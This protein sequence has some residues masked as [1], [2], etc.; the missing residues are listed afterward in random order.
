MSITVAR[1]ASLDYVCRPNASTDYPC[2]SGPSPARVTGAGFAQKSSKIIKILLFRDQ[3]YNLKCIGF[4]MCQHICQLLG[5]GSRPGGVLQIL[6]LLLRG[7][8]WSWSKLANSEHVYHFINFITF[9]V[10]STD[11]AMLWFDWQKQ[12][13]T[14]HHKPQRSTKHHPDAKPPRDGNKPAAQALCCLHTQR[15]VVPKRNLGLGVQD[16]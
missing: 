11:A 4:G 1:M 7:N 15:R 6:Q 9:Q 14:N 3:M 13:L 8:M 16:T 2:S 10:V 5:V 12:K